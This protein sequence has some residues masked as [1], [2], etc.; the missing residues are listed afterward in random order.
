MQS[1]TPGET[2]PNESLVDI[3][4]QLVPVDH[5][6]EMCLRLAT[7]RPGGWPFRLMLVSTPAL[8][9][10]ARG[11]PPLG[12]IHRA[13][14][15]LAAGMA[16]GLRPDPDLMLAASLRVPGEQRRPAALEALHGAAS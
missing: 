14:A 11:M 10:V 6:R 7:I 8:R 2:R 1:P 13:R 5:W 4:G 16:L 3:D 9:A 15:L 12:E